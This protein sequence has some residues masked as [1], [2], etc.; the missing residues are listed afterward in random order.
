MSVREIIKKELE[1]S[2]SH[3]ED[4]VQRAQRQLI[5][6]PYDHDTRDALENIYKPWR[7]KA[8]KAIDYLN[9]HPEIL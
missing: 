2:L 5:R 3:A 9:E 8:Q 6:M 4:N 7:E 1:A